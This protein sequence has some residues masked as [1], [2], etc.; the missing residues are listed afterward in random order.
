MFCNSR[1][2]VF[3]SFD[4]KKGTLFDGIFSDVSH[5]FRQ[6]HRIIA[7]LGSKSNTSRAD[8][9]ASSILGTFVGHTSSLAGVALSRNMLEAP[10]LAGASSRD[11]YAPSLTTFIIRK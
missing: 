1:F 6:F 11:H 3:S 7:R 4:L 2:V 5:L 8:N 9:R 10:K